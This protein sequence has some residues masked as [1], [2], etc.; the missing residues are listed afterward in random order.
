MKKTHFFTVLTAFILAVSFLSFTAF[1]ENDTPPAKMDED[2]DTTLLIDGFEDNAELSGWN[3][4]T[5]GVIVAVSEYGSGEEAGTG[6][7]VTRPYFPDEGEVSLTVS[8]VFSQPLD[9]K[10]YKT[11]SFDFIQESENEEK[12]F[13]VTVE[14][15]GENESA[16]YQRSY[17]AGKVKGLSADISALDYRDE[18]KE[19]RITAAVPHDPDNQTLSFAIDNLL[20]EG[21][22]D[23]EIYD[24]FLST[25]YYTSNGKVQYSEGYI[26]FAPEDD[27]YLSATV[28]AFRKDSADGILIELE[29]GDYSGN[30]SFSYV[31]SDGGTYIGDSAIRISVSSSGGIYY[32]EAPDIASA[33]R[34]TVRAEEMT[35]EIKIKRIIPVEL[36]LSR[37]SSQPGTYS[38]AKLANGG[39]TVRVTGSII[40]DVVSKHSGSRLGLFSLSAGEGVDTILSGEKKPLSTTPIS[41]KFDFKI[42]VT[43]DD[44][45][46]VARR[47]LVAILPNDS[48]A[49][50][51]FI[52]SPVFISN[53]YGQS[54][55]ATG[56][57]GNMYDGFTVGSSNQISSG[58]FTVIDV[59]L[60][61][62]CSHS[63][64]GEMHK[65]GNIFRYYNTDYLSVLDRKIKALC[66]SEI[67][68]RFTASQKEGEDGYPG[69]PLLAVNGSEG[70]DFYMVSNFLS[71]RYSGGE[72]GKINGF[73]LGYAANMRDSI[74][75]DSSLSFSEYVSS[76]A[77]TLRIIYSGGAIDS[78]I[79]VFAATDDSIAGGIGTEEDGY[80]SP[81]LFLNALSSEMKE[82]GECPWYLCIDS[83]S[84]PLTD[85]GE[86]LTAAN[87]AILSA[88]LMRINDSTSMG[89][90]GVMY[91][92]SP[93]E[94]SENIKDSYLYSVLKF[95]ASSDIFRFAVSST[96]PLTELWEENG[97]DISGISAEVLQRLTSEGID[98]EKAL[99]D[100][101][102]SRRTV[103]HG[104]LLPSLPTSILGSYRYFD[105]TELYGSGGFS[106]T[107]SG[108]DI[109][110]ESVSGKR[111]M[112]TV[113]D[114]SSPVSA[115]IIYR[116]K[117]PENMSVSPYVSLDIEIPEA[118]GEKTVTVIFGGEVASAE[119]SAPLSGR[120]EMICDI[121]GFSEK[122][123]VKYIKITV[124]DL[125]EGLEI[126]TYS[127]TGHSIYYTDDSLEAVILKERELSAAADPD[128][129]PV[130]RT[131][132]TIA[133][134]VFTVFTVAVILALSRKKRPDSD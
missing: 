41:M 92:W 72:N 75:P 78:D 91:I 96:V 17:T 40:S 42:A 60:S 36:G 15:I 3:S 46:A 95:T 53:P 32:A 120:G 116:F 85:N 77:D 86:H 108:V 127:V 33:V 115:G 38:D 79:K 94:N 69:H 51:V 93:D 43:A 113:F 100:A 9:L 8:K 59:D 112:K 133:I 20:A 67:Y 104:T 89:N 2:T 10:Y 114:E 52:G 99:Q 101:L 102:R 28:P 73:I 110:S 106:P 39:K 63:G 132:L 74:S 130:S 84:D 45:Q 76:Y 64:T 111:R 48:T 37:F 109:L 61:L 12:S 30:L 22:M 131:Y 7:S 31:T 55:S 123:A 66:C 121:S 16:K 81:V 98:T 58:G 56:K 35:G 105:F 118:A 5:E 47:Y 126:Y 29:G 117:N 49:S 80:Y 65:A 27:K 129:S 62:L 24:R 54:S 107:D 50:H 34:W 122:E 57:S 11:V 21:Y 124:S 88:Y 68:L 90:D 70:T 71:S 19:I 82:R 23:P 13:E 83:S 14:I 1:A 25:D 4:D 97:P 26:L 119:F 6:L 125:D 134:V 87:S 128:D 44:P 103:I 18:I